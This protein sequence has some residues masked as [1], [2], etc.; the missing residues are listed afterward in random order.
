MTQKT[1]PLPGLTAARRT[2]TQGG[3]MA[4]QTIMLAAIGI[5][6]FTLMSINGVTKPARSISTL[7]AALLYVQVNNNLECLS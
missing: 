1:K 7:C 4:F 3:T 6:S 5:V 2:S